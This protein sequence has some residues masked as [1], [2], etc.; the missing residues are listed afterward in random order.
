MKFVT[1]KIDERYGVSEDGRIYSYITNKLLRPNKSKQGYLYFSPGANRK[2]SIHRQVAFAYVPN[3]NNYPVVNHKDGNK[4]NNHYTNLEWT[5]HSQNTKHAF[6]N[7]LIMPAGLGR[8]GK[9]NA[10]SK[11]VLQFTL[12][13][14]FI[15]EWECAYQAEREA[16]FNSATISEVCNGKHKSHKGYIFKYK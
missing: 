2:A 8:L 7:K 10:R 14:I 9:L 5:T 16:G 6:E 11:P 1:T 4:S 15:R 3:P 13:S 12:E